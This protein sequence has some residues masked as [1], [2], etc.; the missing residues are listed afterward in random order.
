L[1]LFRGEGVPPLRSIL[2]CLAAFWALSGV[3]LADSRT[4]AGI[5]AAILPLQATEPETADAEQRDIMPMTASLPW[6]AVGFLDNGC[7]ATL[8]DRQHIL[9]ASHCFTFDYDGQT[10]AGIQYSQGAWQPG[11]TYFPNF[12]P[13]RPNPPRVAVDRVIVGSRVQT[14][15]AQPSAGA[16]WGIGHLAA[17]ITAFPALPLLP[18]ERWQYP[19]FV[20]FGGYARDEATYLQKS[21]SFPE[22]APGGYCANFKNNCWWI[23]AFVDPKCLA[24]E[25]N[26]GVVRIDNHSCLVQ[27]GNSGSP[28][29]WNTGTGATPSYQ[30]TGVVSGGG[31]YWSSSR[32]RHAPRFAGGV[33]IAS[34]N[35]NAS[36][37]Q[38]FVS[39]ND[40][41]RVVSRT[42]AVDAPIGAFYWF[43]DR[44]EVHGPGPLA[45]FV[46]PNGKPLVV[47]VSAN[48][49][50]FA[51]RADAAGRWLTWSNITLPAGVTGILDLAATIDIAGLP[52]LYAIGNNRA[53]YLRRATKAAATVTWG[54]WTLLAAGLHARRVAAIRHEDG[55]QQAFLVSTSGQLQ[56]M[57][58]SGNAAGSQW[59]APTPFGDPALPPVADLDAVLTADGAVQV[60]AIDQGGAGWTRQITGKSPI[61]LWGSWSAWELPLYAPTAATPPTL[62]G[63]VSITA[64]RGMEKGAEAV[65]MVF[66]TDR[67]G[68]IYLTNQV[69]GQWRPWRSFYN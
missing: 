22:P 14:D 24:I 44:G 36:R 4:A 16:D 26:D 51:S 64:G 45:A 56:T 55:R 28:V 60:F 1:I 35:G 37:T 2:S 48:G 38:V 32:F 33:A 57:W 58:Q 63:L 67:Q 47:A 66:A 65:P 25:E 40:L 41:G 9:A 12:H 29:L 21:A 50:L 69:D 10:A 39:D 34:A 62:D 5:S 61:T 68:N 46:L 19:N 42:R 20:I 6:G 15:P 8:I 27:G 30:I 18:M 23:P 3:A 43:E 54:P 49:N 13:G 53:L 11:L 7:T 59:N 31:G 17:P 52:C